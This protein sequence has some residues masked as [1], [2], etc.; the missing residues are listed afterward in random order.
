MGPPG[1]SAGAAR[2]FKAW[3]RAPGGRSA[4]H[5]GLGGGGGQQQEEEG[6]PRVLRGC[7][8]VRSPEERRPCWDSS[9]PSRQA[10]GGGGG[11]GSCF[12]FAA[13][14]RDKVQRVRGGFALSGPR[15][16]E[17]SRN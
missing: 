8:Q 13:W 1:G 9:E 16:P 11:G 17:R 3:G 2:A 15:A 10:P 4:R 5:H 14:S 6:A 12:S 7:L